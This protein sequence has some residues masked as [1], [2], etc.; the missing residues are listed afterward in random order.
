MENLDNI[1]DLILYCL[2]VKFFTGN[3]SYL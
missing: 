3:R 2:L 1:S